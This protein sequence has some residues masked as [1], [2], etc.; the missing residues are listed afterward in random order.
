MKTDAFNNRTPR[1]EIRS[2]SRG[3]QFNASFKKERHDEPAQFPTSEIEE[4]RRVSETRDARTNRSQRG[5]RGSGSRSSQNRSAGNAARNV[6][7]AVARQAVV[8]VSGA[9]IVTNSY[10]TMVEEREERAAVRERTLA[11]EAATAAHGIDLDGVADGTC[12][13]VWE[14]GNESVL[15]LIPGVGLADATVTIEEEAPGC[16]TPGTRTYT[17]TAVIG[18]ESFTDSQTEEIPATGHSFGEP[19]ISTDA[20][21]NPVIRVHC[22]GCDQ[23]FEIGYNIEKIE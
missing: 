21:G 10:Q 17:A 12:V 14:E 11:I 23:D 19:E 22:S 2:G 6:A 18:E 20:D 4:V 13:W 9:V 1:N 3:D 7:N 16:V 15:L 8:M 5:D